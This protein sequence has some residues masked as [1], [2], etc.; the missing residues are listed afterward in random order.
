[1]TL[2]RSLRYVLLASLTL[3]GAACEQESTATTPPAP[4][5]GESPTQAGVV[6][7]L[8]AWLKQPGNADDRR[9]VIEASN[10]FKKVP[11]V[12]DVYAGPVL[13]SDRAVVDS[14]FDVGVVM[15]FKDEQSLKAYVTHPGHERAVKEVL[16]PKVER[17]KVY[18]FTVVP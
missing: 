6:H 2:K 14:T 12:L 7:V 4:A 17:A 1:M 9:M 5:A 18:D 10:N 15:L 13:P 3:S 8:V 16:G 11:G